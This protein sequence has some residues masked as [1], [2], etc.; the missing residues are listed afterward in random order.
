MAPL[1]EIGGDPILD[2][3]ERQRPSRDAP[4]EADDVEAVAGLVADRPEDPGR[5]VD[6]REVVQ[7]PQDAGLEIVPVASVIGC[8]VADVGVLVP[9]AVALW[10]GES[11][12]IFVAAGAI[13]SGLGFAIERATAGAS[14]RVGVRE[15]FLVVSATWLLAAGFG[16]LP[17]L[18]SGS[19]QLGSP[20]DAYFE[21]KVTLFDAA[22]TQR[23]VINT[24][25]PY[26]RRIVERAGGSLD[27]LTYGDEAAD[28]ALE[29][30]NLQARRRPRFAP[31]HIGE[32]LKAIEKLLHQVGIIL[33]RQGTE[34]VAA[35][36]FN[37]NEE[38]AFVVG[39]D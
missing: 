8:A 5:I 10:Y 22:Y 3:V 37:P 17:Y 16:A 36:L 18:L 31:G 11:V 26:G 30:V 27:V 28:I 38:N 2:G 12:W 35:E 13:T 4:L 9:I 6:E 25:D 19:E 33:R 24:S 14:E 21:A 39:A 20:V 34:A 7:D 1:D 23:A 32:A 15:G 29:Q